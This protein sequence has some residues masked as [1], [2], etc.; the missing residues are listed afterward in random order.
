MYCDIFLYKIF[1]IIMC[2]LSCITRVI[3]EGGDSDSCDI[4]ISSFHVQILCNNSSLEIFEGDECINHVPVSC[5]QHYIKEMF[6]FV[7]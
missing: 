2:Y 4:S 5:T 7:V 1:L 6:S 3:G